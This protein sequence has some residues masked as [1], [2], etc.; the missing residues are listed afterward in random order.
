MTREELNCF[1][2]DMYEFIKFVQNAYHTEYEQELKIK[3]TLLHDLSGILNKDE[4]F[5]PRV[6]GMSIE[7]QT[8]KNK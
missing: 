7:K 3:G 8:I 5:V 4:H 1:V 2:D 6:D